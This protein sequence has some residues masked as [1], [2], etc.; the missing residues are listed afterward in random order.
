[1]VRQKLSTTT[2]QCRNLEDLSTKEKKARIDKK[3][4]QQKRKRGQSKNL[5]EKTEE[6][7]VNESN[8]KRL[9]SQHKESQESAADSH[10]PA[11]NH[12]SPLN[13][14]TDAT[15]PALT[16]THIKKSK[17]AS[18][19][20]ILAFELNITSYVFYC[21]LLRSSQPETLEQRRSSHL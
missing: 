16:F 15:K 9:K 1:M 11:D 13:V 18:T 3:T 17:P 4:K 20:F 5:D 19:I 2:K 10:D 14:A 12:T 8:R 7:P 21:R 6:A